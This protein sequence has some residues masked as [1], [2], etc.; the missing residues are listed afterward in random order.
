[1]YIFRYINYSED[2]S[3]ENEII[4]NKSHHVFYLSVLADTS[5]R[6]VGGC[7]YGRLEVL[8][9]DTSTWGTVCDSDKVNEAYVNDVC[10]SL[11]Y[12][13]GE[14]LGI[15]GYKASSQQFAIKVDCTG[16]S[17]DV[18]GNLID[19]DHDNDVGIVCTGNLNIH[20]QHVYERK[21]A[22]HHITI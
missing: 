4:T 8:V 3:K 20:F 19:C 15:E 18:V 7:G 1:M 6:L 11:G 9:P 16:D 2:K 13:G 12:S 10:I 17:C 21:T 22:G 14:P 5:F